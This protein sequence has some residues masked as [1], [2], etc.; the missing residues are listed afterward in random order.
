MIILLLL[1]LFSPAYAQDEEPV[2]PQDPKARARIDAARAA[3]ITERLG[4]SAD[5][6]EKFWPI[7]REFAGKR[8]ELQQQLREARRE[9]KSDDELVELGLTIKQRELDLEKEYSG[10]MMRVI[11]AQKLM[12]LRPAEREFTRIIIQQIQQRQQQQDRRQ[13]Y[14]ER[15][16]QRIQQRNN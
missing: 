3:Y 2:T 4:L 9:G 14:R 1:C 12:N 8:Q 10:Q 16:Q 7:Y 15:Q 13:Q 11:T 5:E 6:A